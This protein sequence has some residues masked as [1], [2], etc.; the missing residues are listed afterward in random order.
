MADPSLSD[1]RR[2]ESFENID[3]AVRVLTAVIQHRKADPNE[4][5]ELC[6]FAPEAADKSINELACAVIRIALKN[7]MH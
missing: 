7:A 3:R 4:L 1:N 6:R 2:R 5:A